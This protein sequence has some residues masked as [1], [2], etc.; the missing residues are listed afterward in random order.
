MA[1][2]SNPSAW[3]SWIRLPALFLF[4]LARDLEMILTFRFTPC[5]NI[6]PAELVVHIRFVRRQLRRHLEI[7]DCVFNLALLQQRLAEF[8]MCV[9]EIWFAL[10]HFAHQLDSGRSLL[11]SEQHETQMIFGLH[12]VRIQG[13]FTFK[14]LRCLVKL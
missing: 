1:K 4:Q 2:V 3:S 13:Q 5:G 12:V 7:P 10:N 8:V 6:S 11:L 14:F 9:S